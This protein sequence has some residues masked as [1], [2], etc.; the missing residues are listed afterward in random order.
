MHTRCK[1]R[2]EGREGGREGGRE[3]RKEEGRTYMSRERGPVEHGR[4]VRDK[5]GVMRRLGDD[6]GACR[7]NVLGV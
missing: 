4:D 5:G 3:K 1:G 2:E 7:G 6:Y